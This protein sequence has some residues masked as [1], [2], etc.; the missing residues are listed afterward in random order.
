MTP[1]A[2]PNW[3]RFFATVGNFPPQIVDPALLRSAGR[4]DVTSR[5]VSGAALWGI[6]AG[7]SFVLGGL[8]ALHR[9]MSPR[10]VGLV[11]GLGSGALIGAVAYELVDEASSLANGSGR[12]AAGLALG[13]VASYVVGGNWRG[14]SEAVSDRRLLT[15]AALD[16]GCEAIVIVGSLLAGH[17]IGTAVIVAVFL[18]GAPS[19]IAWTDRLRA[20][21]HSRRVITTV[22]LS[23][24]LFSAI[25][26]F[27]GYG[28]LDAAS[29]DVTA[30]VLASAAGALFVTVLV[31]LL[32]TARLLAGP[33]VSLAAVLGFGLSFALIELG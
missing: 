22:W 15:G 12:A 25:V 4:R 32:P 6:V 16:V 13:A 26:A 24:M 5:P 29:D 2:K 1:P 14:G 30:F 27:V 10:L 8:V 28:L 21:G 11:L 33:V 17:G 9:A 31:D 7:A 20:G 23:L 19:A 18:C 3:A